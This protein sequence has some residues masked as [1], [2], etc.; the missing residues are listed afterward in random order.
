MRGR[1]SFSAPTTSSQLGLASH[2]FHSAHRVLPP[3]FGFLP[4][5][6]L[7]NGNAA[8]GPLFYHLLPYVEQQSLYQKS[9]HQPPSSPQQDFFFYHGND[10]HRRLIPVYVCP[11]DPTVPGDGINPLRSAA[12]SSYAGNHIVFGEVDKE[13]RHVYAHGKGRLPST[14]ADGT[15]QTILFAEKYAVASISAEDHSGGESYEG[16]CHWSYFQ[17]DCYNA[18]FAFY[19]PDS[20]DTNSVGPL[21][22]GDKRDGRFQI[23]PA[24]QKCNPCLPASA[25]A[26][27]N[28]CFADGSVRSLAAGLSRRVWWA[29]VTPAGNEHA[30]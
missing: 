13:Y 24:P 29:Y 26:T 30:E 9:R 27:M 19:H 17:A 12:V 22:A 6:D 7:Y 4:R 10:V 28:A 2:S 21:H 8:L 14:F 20:T 5:A 3:S 15:S 11:S 16:G 1:P 23:R 18:L 25:H